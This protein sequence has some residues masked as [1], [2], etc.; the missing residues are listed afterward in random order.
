MCFDRIETWTCVNCV[1]SEIYF[2]RSSPLT[3]ELHTLLI[4]PVAM[5][6]VLTLWLNDL[7]TADFNRNGERGE[8]TNIVDQTFGLSMKLTGIILRGKRIKLSFVCLP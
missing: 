2:I 3:I 6:K 7:T 8:D 1:F 4:L 5:V